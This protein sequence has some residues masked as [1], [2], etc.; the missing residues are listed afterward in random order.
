MMYEQIYEL[1]VSRKYTFPENCMT[2][3]VMAD[4]FAADNL[5]KKF[6]K[7]YFRNEKGVVKRRPHYQLRNKFLY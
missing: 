4:P 7:L 1:V 5:I 2:H 6:D 3:N